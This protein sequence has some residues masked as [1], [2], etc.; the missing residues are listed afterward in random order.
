MRGRRHLS[1]LLHALLGLT[2][3]P[4]V[5]PG[6][7]MVHLF[8]VQAGLSLHTSVPL[9]QHEPGLAHLHRLTAGG[10]SLWRGEG[11]QWVETPRRQAGSHWDLSKS[12]CSW[13][14][15]KKNTGQKWLTEAIAAYSPWNVVSGSF[16]TSWMSRRYALGV[17]LVSLLLLGKFTTVPCFHHSWF[18]V[19][20]WLRR[21]EKRTL[22]H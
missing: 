8:T 12:Q 11:T 15:H 9:W 16:V 18:H 19:I 17:I 7:R 3:W 14:Q 10:P 21:D 2:L 22:A 5:A 13:I 4:H 6:D 20:S 1:A